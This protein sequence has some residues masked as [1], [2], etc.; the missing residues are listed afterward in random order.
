MN[1]SILKSIE[2]AKKLFPSAYDAK[3]R[4]RTFHFSFAW[5][6]NKLLSIGQNVPHYPSGKALKF[7]KMFNT[8]KTIRY[9]YL[10]SEVD[11]IS[12]LW[13]KTRVDGNLKVISIRINRFGNL[14]NSKPCKSCSTILSALDVSDIWWSNGGGKITDGN[15][16]LDFS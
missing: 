12:K 2:I 9:P 4:Y 3:K 14:C 6:R 13:G 5:K 8:P 16:L 10:H 7:A 15:F 1:K 11:M